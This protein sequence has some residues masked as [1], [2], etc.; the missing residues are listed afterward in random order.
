MMKYRAKL[1]AKRRAIFVS[2]TTANTVRDLMSHFATGIERCPKAVAG[3]I[4]CKISQ[5]FAA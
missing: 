3:A 1:A 2:I 5:K 4:L